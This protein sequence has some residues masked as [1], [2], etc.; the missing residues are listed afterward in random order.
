MGLALTEKLIGQH[1]GRIDFRTGPGGTTF[2]IIGPPGAAGRER[3]VSH[4]RTGLS[5]PDR[6]RRA[7]HPLRAGAWRWQEESYEVATASDAAEA[8]ALFRRTP[9]HLVITD[10]K[11]PG[12]ISGLDLVRE[13][14]HG[15]P[16]TLILVIT[17][18]GSVETAVEAM[19]LGA[20][21]Y[22]TKPVD[23]DDAAAPGPQ[24]LR[25]PPPA[26][27]EPPAPRLP[28]GRGRV[29]GDD[30][31]ERRDA[32]GLRVHPPGRRHRPDGADPG[33]ERHGQGAGRPGDPQ[34]ERRRERAVRRRRTSGRCPRRSSRAS[35][36]ATRRGPS[37]APSAASRAGSR[38]RRAGTL[39]LDEVGEMAPKTQVDLLRVLEQRE[40][41]RLGGE[42]LDPA[43]RA[44]GGRD[45]SRRRRAGRRGQ[46][47]RGP[48]LPPQ[49][50]PPARAARCAS[51]ATTS[52]CWSS[53]SSRGPARGTGASPRQVAGAAM[54]IL[55]DYSWPGNVRQ[56]RN[57]MERLVVTVEG[58]DDPRRGPAA[59]DAEHAAA[60]GSRPSTRRS[61]RRRRRRS[62]RPWPS[63]TTT[64]SAP[65]GCWGSASAPCS[66][67]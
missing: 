47:P 3:T 7:E 29:P 33:G 58:P 28:G 31:P 4:E 9:H 42:E 59:G 5:H 20:H 17:A 26:R 44:A 27:G 64:A 60:R 51:G 1:G 38:W 57:C 32:R 66:T 63:A 19:R 49:R 13:I 35:C 50:G 45:P 22:I 12:P 34:P 11:M 53:I 56:L 37:A 41:R 39:F 18:H 55:C 16:E 30:R 15:W 65:P 36:S 23:L 54:R 2:C 67:R 40:V 46:A 25:A 48:L 14:K 52:R 21:D 43:R 10:L 61:R 24:G 6:G 62:S 8:W